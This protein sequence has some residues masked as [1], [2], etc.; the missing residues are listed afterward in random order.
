MFI[1][2][3]FVDAISFIASA[4]NSSFFMESCGIALCLK[5]QSSQ[6]KPLPRRK[7]VFLFCV[8]DEDKCVNSFFRI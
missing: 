2:T 7:L 8:V 3:P 4:I 1:C 5:G 6:I